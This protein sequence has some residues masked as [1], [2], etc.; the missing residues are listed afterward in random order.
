MPLRRSANRARRSVAGVSEP[1][2][3]A[4]RANGYSTVIG[5]ACPCD[6]QIE[7]ARIDVVR[8]RPPRKRIRP[9]TSTTSARDEIW[10]RRARARLPLR[11]AAASGDC[12]EPEGEQAAARRRFVW[13]AVELG[14]TMNVLRRQ[15]RSAGESERPTSRMT[16]GFFR[17]AGVPAG[18]PGESRSR[19]LGGRRCDG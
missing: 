11:L 3:E 5:T 18:W 12:V 6:P 4:N 2:R 9:G 15:T 7:D 16:T 1:V 17:C 19:P 14:F 10:N 8:S 13:M